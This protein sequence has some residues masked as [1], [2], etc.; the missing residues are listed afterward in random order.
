MAITFG[1]P[2]WRYLL[3]AWLMLT[4]LSLGLFHRHE[5]SAA[6][7]VQQTAPTAWHYHLALFG[8]HLDFLSVNADTSPFGQEAPPSKEVHLLLGSVFA[9][10]QQQRSADLVPSL[11]L[12]FPSPSPVTAALTA[13]NSAAEDSAANSADHVLLPEIA[14]GARSGVQQI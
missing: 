9:S 10:D 7:A 4:N 2:T 1:L 11:S 3:V 13:P 6:S 8:L 5:E 14:L 12:D